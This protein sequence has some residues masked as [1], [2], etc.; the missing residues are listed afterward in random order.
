MTVGR[1]REIHVRKGAFGHNAHHPISFTSQQCKSVRIEE[2]AFSR[3]QRIVL[4]VIDQLH[5][6][7]NAFRFSGLPSSD[8]NVINADI[9]IN[10]ATLKGSSLTC[11]L[12]VYVLKS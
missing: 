9:T 6:D 12:G 10:S 7:A 2:S 11:L 4:S 1:C 5:L 8:N 3:V